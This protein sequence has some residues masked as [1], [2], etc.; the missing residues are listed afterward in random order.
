MDMKRQVFQKR[1]VYQA[2]FVGAIRLVTGSVFYC[3]VYFVSCKT[4]ISEM[5]PKVHL[6][7]L[8]S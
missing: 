2:Y 4:Y 5:I 3:I 6:C 8:V 1:L 7:D